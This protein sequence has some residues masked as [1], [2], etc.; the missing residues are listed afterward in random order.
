VNEPIKWIRSP[1]DWEALSC[2]LEAVDSELQV[3][4]HTDITWD[5]TD[6]TLD[7]YSVCDIPCVISMPIDLELWIQNS[8]SIGI[9]ISHPMCYLY[10][11]WDITDVK[12]VITYITW[13][14]YSVHMGYHRYAMGYYIHHMGW[15]LGMW[16]PCDICISHG[17]WQICHGIPQI[18]HWLSTRYVISHVLFLCLSIWSFGFRVD[19]LGIFADAFT[20]ADETA[21]ETYAFTPLPPLLL[22]RNEPLWNT[23]C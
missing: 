4:G 17:I 7:E 12:W 10:I 16:I 18:W 3:D 11:T 5:P 8:K 15:V 1:T 6:M 13:A 9:R 21:Q 23:S 22:R 14:E 19:T 20:A 2:S